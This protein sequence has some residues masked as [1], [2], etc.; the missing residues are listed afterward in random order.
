MSLTAHACT[1]HV[2][3]TLGS[4]ARYIYHGPVGEDSLA[5][6]HAFVRGHDTCALQRTELLRLKPESHQPA[7]GKKWR[8]DAASPHCPCGSLFIDP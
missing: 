1:I 7:V 8:G 6:V 2:I 3:K 4:I 5:Y